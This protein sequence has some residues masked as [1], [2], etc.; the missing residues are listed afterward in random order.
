MSRPR[1]RR[2]SGSH[3]RR[4]GKPLRRRLGPRLPGGGRILALGLFTLAIAG[5]VAGVYGPWMRVTALGHSG[6]AYTPSGAVQEIL[7][8]YRGLPILAVDRAGLRDRLASLPTVADAEVEL[9]LPGELQVAIT[10]KDPAFLWQTPRAVLVGARDGTIIAE[11][12]LNGVPPHALRG[13]PRVEDDRFLARLLA[14]GDAVPAAELRVARRLTALDPRLIGSRADSLAVRLD[15]QLGFV[16][17]SSQPAWRAALGFYQLDP[18]EDQAA[19]DARLEQQLAA[20]RTLFA[21]HAERNVSWLD[22]RN[23]GKVYWTP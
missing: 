9:R 12:P 7:D 13:L 23:P 6:D 1:A 21:A 17:E 15:Y 2:R 11:L 18:R 3:A 5:L 16:L 22:A 20:I 19:A 4:P 8:D 10:E 14:A